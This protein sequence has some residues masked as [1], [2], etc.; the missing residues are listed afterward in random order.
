MTA[1]RAVFRVFALGPVVLVVL[2]VALGIAA[3]PSPAV[4]PPAGRCGS[5]PPPF[6]MP[7]SQ[8]TGVQVDGGD[9]FGA[10]VIGLVAVAAVVADRDRCGRSTPRQSSVYTDADA[11]WTAPPQTPVV[12]RPRSGVAGSPAV[13]AAAA[14]KAEDL[15]QGQPAGAGRPGAAVEGRDRAGFRRIRGRLAGVEAAGRLHEGL[16]PRQL[17]LRAPPPVR[18]FADA[19]LR[20]DRRHQDRRWSSTTRTSAITSASATRSR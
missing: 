7:V 12:D 3:R 15:A 17:N 11:A 9:S 4:C 19:R 2:L 18:F 5:R 6:V 16:D 13:E 10:I 20:P 8:P 1:P 14:P